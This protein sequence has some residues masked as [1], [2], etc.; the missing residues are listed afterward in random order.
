[1]MR[2]SNNVVIANTDN[3]IGQVIGGE[4]GRIAVRQKAGVELEIGDIL[5]MDSGD[6]DDGKNDTNNNNIISHQKMILS[7]SDLYYSSQID[8]KTHEMISGV[9]LEERPAAAAFYEPDLVNYVIANV[10]PLVQV[11]SDTSNDIGSDGRHNNKNVTPAAPSTPKSMP[12]FHGTL[13]P[14][15]RDDLRFLTDS[16]YAGRAGGLFVGSIRSGSEV[17]HDAE[18]WLPIEE[19]LTH[20]VL[21]PATTGRGKSNLVKSMLWHIMDAGP[22]AGML[23]LDAHDEYY[24]RTGKGLRDHNGAK[25]RVAYYTTDPSTLP[26]ARTLAINL[27]SIEPHHLEGIVEFSEAQLGAIYAYHSKHGEQWIEAMMGSFDDDSNSENVDLAAMDKVNKKTTSSRASRD[28]PAK[29]TLSVVRRKLGMLLGL[30][31]GNDGC[32][33]SESGVFDAGGR[34]LTTADDMVHL[35]ESGK[36]VILDASQ[37]GSEAELVVGNVVATRLLERYR[38]YKTTGELARKPVASIVI[39]EAPRVIGTDALKSKSDNIYATIAR[40][41]RKFKVGLVAITQLA[42]VIPRTI[43][44]NMTTKI[45]LGNEMGQ[46]REALIA[47]ASQDLSKDDKNIA[48]LD[49]GEAIITSIF[50]PF[51]IPVKI[52]DFDNVVA[53]Y[54]N[55]ANNTEAPHAPGKIRVFG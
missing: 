45:I 19:V 9:A 46:E 32:L 33:Y 44:A 30:R 55:N 22:R 51:A 39:E 8:D 23:V 17:I 6:D 25:D 38:Y 21:I 4:F 47:S 16:K 26:G 18:V 35:I 3:V 1:M 49:R 52:P 53:S 5:V 31:A 10:K 20:H 42:S 13:R 40:E 36:I 29:S 43:L 12:R 41:G 27:K 37:L 7:V 48:S 50:V 14:V 11:A 54:R 28:K 24:G 2:R 34:G 15:S